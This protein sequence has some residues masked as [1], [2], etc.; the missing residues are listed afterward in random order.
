MHVTGDIGI[1]DQYCYHTKSSSIEVFFKVWYA[2]GP[3]S[4]ACFKPPCDSS[5][6][7]NQKLKTET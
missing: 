7:Y 1:H 5:D 4:L 2:D 3:F 6:S